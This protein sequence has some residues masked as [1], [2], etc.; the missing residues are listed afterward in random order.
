MPS[1]WSASLRFEL[2]FTGENINLWGDKLNAVLTHA[3]F[4]TAGVTTKALTGDY[5]LTT[6]NA[7]DDEARAA[8]LKFTG[9]G[10]FTITI[11][12]V[13]KTYDIWNLCAAALTITTGAG[14][15]SVLQPTEVVRVIC[16]GANVKRVVATDFGA[17]RLTSVA[18]PINAQ[19]VA[20]KAYADALAFIANSGVLPGQTGAGGWALFSNGSNALWR[21]ITSADLSDTAAR[22]AAALGRAVAMAVAL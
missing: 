19:D 21:Q 11:P 20:T 14:A 10:P 16:D 15:T 12:S 8:I 1:S 7:A 18:D 6:T 2:Q 9:A 13:S 17:V 5:T 3:D 22:D 4:S